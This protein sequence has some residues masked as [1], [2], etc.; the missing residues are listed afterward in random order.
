MN[1]HWSWEI[2]N[3]KSI[4][5]DESHVLG[6]RFEHALASLTPLN[7]NPNLA[8][9]AMATAN[10]NTNEISPN[11]DHPPEGIFKD[12]KFFIQKDLPVPEATLI[13]AIQVCPPLVVIAV[14]DD[15]ACYIGSGRSH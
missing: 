15:V 1:F 12:I 9:V 13:E 2:S 11:P 10:Q 6:A 5:G 14:G 4:T 3:A 7:A 8:A